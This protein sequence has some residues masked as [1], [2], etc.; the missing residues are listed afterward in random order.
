MYAKAE[1]SKLPIPNGFTKR[2]CSKI[3]FAKA[4]VFLALIVASGFFVYKVWLEFVNHRT[5]FSMGIEKN[6]GIESP[7]TVLCFDSPIKTSLKEEFKLDSN[8]ADNFYTIPGTKDES[9]K[10]NVIFSDNFYENFGYVIQ[11]DFSLKIDGFYKGQDYF[12]VNL[13]EGDNYIWQNQS[14][15]VLTYFEKPYSLFLTFHIL[16]RLL[17]KGSIA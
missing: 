12:Y 4:M 1:I 17:L 15:K 9:V 6:D 14:I 2:Y 13:K 5:T 11:R 16:I 3:N 7:S 8:L 10:N